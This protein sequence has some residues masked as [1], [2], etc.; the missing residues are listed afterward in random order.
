LRR[1]PPLL[2]AY[3]ALQMALFPMAIVT[4]F[5]NGDLGFS[6]TEIMLLQAIFGVA[7]VVLEFPSGYLADRIGYRSAL[8]LG[9]LGSIAGWTAH[10]SATSFWTV[11]SAE[12]LLGAG[13]SLV[14]G[15]DTA[16]LYESLVETEREPEYGRWYGRMR[17]FG[18]AAEGSAALGAGLLY[19]L[20][21][22]L[23]MT[24]QVGVWI[25]GAAVAWPLVEPARHRPPVA[26]HLAR[27]RAIVR[28][29]A[30]E[31]PGLRA[32]VFATTVFAMTTFVPVWLIAL[33]AAADGV[34][35]GWL[36]PL[37]AAANYTVAV[38]SLASDGLGRRLGTGRALLACTAL[39][40]LGYAGLGF[41]HALFGF[42]FYF[43]ITLSRGLAG[44]VLHHAE[45]RLIPGADRA[46]FLSLRSLLFRATFLVVGPA[47]GA[48]VDRFG[49]RPVI[50]AAGALLSALSVAGGFWLAR[51]TSPSRGE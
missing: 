7:M 15:A 12:V 3:H 11:A 45:Q 44:S 9:A 41:A 46:S 17:A 2:C 49:Q 19:A 10:A 20:W 24:V 1:N 34:P 26:D 27:V 42:A 21:P 32:V 51:A 16:L 25:V 13:L 33:Y 30:R 43:A 29:V 6:M 37:W 36:G 35:V 50:L 39:A 23:P 48:G 40:A 14:S 8:L 28:H 47:V 4:L 38:G 18:Q 22:R 31:N 5:W